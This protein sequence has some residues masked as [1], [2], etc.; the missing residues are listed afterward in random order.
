MTKPKVLVL[1]G[2]GVNCDEE[3]KFAF[4]KAGAKSDK[5]NAEAKK[6]DEP[7]TPTEKETE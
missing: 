2:Y 4:E 1:T 5:D 7:E 6:E 3:T